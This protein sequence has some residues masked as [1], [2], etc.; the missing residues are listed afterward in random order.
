MQ[1]IKL[2]VNVSVATRGVSRNSLS[3]SSGSFALLR[4]MMKELEERVGIGSENQEA[5]FILA[6]TR[7]G[8]PQSLEALSAR[9]MTSLI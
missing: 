6:H 9:F 5:A 3:R 1:Q 2:V 7:S 4:F 8:P